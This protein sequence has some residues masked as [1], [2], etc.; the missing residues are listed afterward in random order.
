[1]QSTFTPP[2]G[3]PQETNNP[4]KAAM[5]VRMS[6][7]HQKYSTENQADAIKEYAA[8]RNLDIITTYADEGKSGLKMDGRDAL[9]NLIE[10]V[11]AKQTEFSTILVLDVTRWGR[12]QD[13][14]E[15]AYYEYICRRAGIG[16][17]YVA[18]QFENDGSPVSTIVKGVKRAM[19]AE[20]SR[21]LS[22]KVFAG[23]CRLIELGYRQG[24]AAGYGLRRMLIDE[25]GE[26]KGELKTREHKSLQTDRVI[27]TPGPAEEREVVQWIYRAFTED[28]LQESVIAAQLNQRGLCTDLGRPWS[29]GTVHQVLTNEKYIGNN[30]FNRISFKLKARR[31]VNTPDMWVR[32]NSVFEAVVEPRYFYTAQG[33]IRER[34]RRFSDVEM[35]DKLRGLQQRQGC[36]SGI[37]I[38]EEE[39][40]PSSSAY[41]HRFGSLIRAYRLIGYEPDRDYQYIEI[42]RQLRKLH[43][44]IIQQTVAKIEALGATAVRDPVS[45]IL[46]VNGEI[47]VSLVVC[48]CLQTKAGSYRWKIYLDTALVPDLT[49]AVRMDANNQQPLDYYLLPALDMENPQL[50]LA[51]D[52]GLA[53]D[54]FRFDDLEAF[55]LLT[56]RVTIRE[57]I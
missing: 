24:G 3:N 43:A 19:A 40:M 9:K 31:V 13:T 8:R 32:A 7:D 52:N 50:R 26:P 29:R 5:Y 42:N 22:G 55:F 1:V 18:E 45:D 12:F 10:D 20:Y 34:N 28:G 33:I 54:A 15:S 35:L 57:A 39:D 47:N 11:Q 27:L 16:V 53:L 44:D 38:D 25:H 4:T 36:L 46:R 17:E 30:V 49:I 37:L 41:Q 6:T 23:Q 21:E 48:R 14:D 51:E 56:E 2:N